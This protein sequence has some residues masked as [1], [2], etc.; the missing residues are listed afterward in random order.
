MTSDLYDFWASYLAE[1]EKRR[2][3]LPYIKHLVIDQLCC[4]AIARVSVEY[5][6]EGDSGQIGTISA[7]DANGKDVDLASSL[8][9]MSE[10][11]DQ[12]LAQ[13]LTMHAQENTVLGLIDAFTWL[14]LD[15]YHDGFV[16]NDGGFGELT[17]DVGAATV[18]L[19]HNDRYVEVDPTT[20]EI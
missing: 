1:R 5:D 2:Q 13:L 17:I 15:A 16:N 18:T 7:I 12:A 11:D 9:P 4:H 20:T 6:G 8:K 19:D 14:L 10:A 3:R